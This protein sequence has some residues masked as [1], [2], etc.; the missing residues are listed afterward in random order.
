MS[1]ERLDSKRWNSNELNGTRGGGIIY[2]EWGEIRQQMFGRIIYLNGRGRT[3]RRE[4]EQKTCVK[5]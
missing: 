4:I 1:E 5:E 2:S 3:E